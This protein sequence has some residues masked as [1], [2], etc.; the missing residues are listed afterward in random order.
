MWNKQYSDFK[1]RQ[2]Q[3]LEELSEEGHKFTTPEISSEIMK[4]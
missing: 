2:A 4:T 1:G 3:W